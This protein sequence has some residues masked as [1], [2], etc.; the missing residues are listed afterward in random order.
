M[1]ISLDSDLIRVEIDQHMFHSGGIDEGLDCGPVDILNGLRWWYTYVGKLLGVGSPFNRPRSSKF[2]YHDARVFDGQSPSLGH[3]MSE[4]SES[5]ASLEAG[6][7]LRHKL[8]ARLAV[9]LRIHRRIRT[10]CRRPDLGGRPSC[11][12]VS[13]SAL[14]CSVFVPPR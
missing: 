14:F 2:P 10:L 12:G 4:R 1:N 7:W 13:R 5:V 8:V 6:G 3:L 11:G 9:L